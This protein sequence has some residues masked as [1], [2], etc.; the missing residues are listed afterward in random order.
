M[1]GRRR[2]VLRRCFP[3][4]RISNVLYG[5]EGRDINTCSISCLYCETSSANLERVGGNP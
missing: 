3:A 4:R 5:E 1:C 2:G